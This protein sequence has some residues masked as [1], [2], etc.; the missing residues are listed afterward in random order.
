MATATIPVDL[1]NP[2]QVFACLGLME[3]AEILIGPATGGFAW[4]GSET[5]ATF[6]LSTDGPDDPMRTVLA[7]LARAEVRALAPAGS[8]L[9]TAAW[10]VETIAPAAGLEGGAD[11]DL[12]DLSPCAPPETPAA[13]PIIL[14]DGVASLPISHWGD[15]FPS[16]GRDNVKFWAGAG[17]YPGAGLA[18]D[19]L[20][21]LAIGDNA[22]AD[23]AAD[24]FSVPAEQSS[25]FRFDW[26]RDYVPLDAGFSPN[27]QGAV[28]MV[29]FPLVELL[30]AIGLEHARPDRPDR[31]DKLA[32][33]Y[34]VS[35]AV[36]PTMLARAVLGAEPLGFPVRIFRMRLGWPGQEGQARC[37]IDAQ[38]EFVP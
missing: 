24:P 37:I 28:R 5:D 34:G 23:A 18:R 14:T 15:D 10:Q 27:L 11:R 12:G 32:Y 36:L 25:S 3:A 38:E 26:R 13:L 35:S 21:A 30:A 17:G 22:L 33:R 20:A 29:G 4:M 19:A 31:R 1:R 6:T 9:S 8:P 7:F 16:T 2:G